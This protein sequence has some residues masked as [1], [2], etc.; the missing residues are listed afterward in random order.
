MQASVRTQAPEIQRTPVAATPGRV[1]QSWPQVPQL[2]GSAETSTHPLSCVTLA[3]IANASGAALPSLRVAASGRGPPSTPVVELP[4]QPPVAMMMIV[5]TQAVVRTLATFFT[6][7]R[8][9]SRKVPGSR[10]R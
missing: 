7:S 4:P 5:M 8:T 10:D 2:R 1:V 9:C 6:P 3:S